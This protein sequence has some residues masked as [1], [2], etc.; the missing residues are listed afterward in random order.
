MIAFYFIIRYSIVQ[1]FNC[2]FSTNLSCVKYSIRIFAAF[3]FYLY[4]ISLSYAQELNCSV[5]VTSQAI[6]DVD[7][8]IFDALQKSIYEFINNRKWT[9]DA[10][11]SH[12]RIECSMLINITNRV[13]TD[14][15]KATLQVQ[16]RR[17]VYKT[18][19]NT[20]SFIIN[21][22]DIQFKYVSFEVL[23]YSENNYV[24]ELTT[25]LAYYVYVIL[26]TDYD[27]FAMY[28]GAPFFQKALTIVNNAQSSPAKGWKA[29][30]GQR[31]R[32]WLIQNIL[33]QQFKPLRECNYKYHRLGIDRM[34]EK[35]DEG[36]VAIT[37]AI[38]SLR[39]LYRIRPNSF[40]MQLFFNAKSD[41]I[42]NV[43]SQAYPEEKT[44]IVAVLNEI[45]AG[46][47]SKYQKI[48][49]SK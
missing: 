3:A 20:T 29:Y 5:Q 49:T 32:Y 8:T 2:S 19:Y 6:A 12:E 15:F 18:S 23:E 25:I 44:R 46:N 35:V 37:E 42:V 31:N 16:S 27:S 26:G 14:E 7:R 24:S 47:T 13:S 21:D 1:M 30:E 39:P 9:G 11:T 36:K 48:L 34:G 43:Y 4:G 45:D 41:E 33:D 22:Q 17:P 28:G 40:N 38:E 10:Y